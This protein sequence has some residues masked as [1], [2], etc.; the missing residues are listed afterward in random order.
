MYN[1]NIIYYPIEYQLGPFSVFTSYNI[2]LLTL[3]LSLRLIFF[4]S[5]M[6]CCLTQYI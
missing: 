5:N 2:F 1:T 4:I 3:N 6:L